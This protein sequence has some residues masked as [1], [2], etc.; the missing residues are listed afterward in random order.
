MVT[1]NLYVPDASVILKWVL[2]TPD[3][4]DRSVALSL[5][6]SWAAGDC[7]FI[8]PSLWIY[9]VGNIIG[10]NIADRAVEFMELLID[11]RIAEEPISAAIAGRTL[12]IM[13]DCGVTFYDAVYHAI[14]LER[15]GTLVTADGAYMKKAGRLG[16]AVL[17][18]DIG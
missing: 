7:E 2:D 17:L 9:E 13:I 16:N 10:R 3:E 12:S 15:K 6:N 11:Y 18:A 8:L 1:S 14:A 4:E 5:L